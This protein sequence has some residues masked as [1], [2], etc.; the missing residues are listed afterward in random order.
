MRGRRSSFGGRFPSKSAAPGGSRATTAAVGEMGDDTLLMLNGLGVPAY[1]AR[2]LTQ[3]LEPIEASAQLR[4]TVNGALV[5]LSYEPFRKYKSTISCS[6]QEPPAVD[7]VW[8]GQVVT[9]ECVVELCFVTATGTAAR[10]AVTGSQRVDSEFTFYRP[11][12]TMRATGFSVSRDEY[13]AA[14]SWQLQLEEI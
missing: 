10:P 14:V 8:P 5:D 7:G 3:T 4:R 9:I 12:L 2:G 6:D 11:V 13:G 1:S